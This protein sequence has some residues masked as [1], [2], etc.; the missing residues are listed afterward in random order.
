[1]LITLSHCVVVRTFLVSTG[2]SV[3]G[4]S[5]TGGGSACFRSFFCNDVL[6]LHK[7]FF[8]RLAGLFSSFRDK[9]ALS[10]MFWI[11]LFRGGSFFSSSPTGLLYFVDGFEETDFSLI[12]T[13]GFLPI[14]LVTS[15][16]RAPKTSGSLY[17]HSVDRFPSGRRISTAY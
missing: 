15:F 1:M 2:G 16:F 3:D 6:C 13:A 7:S 17:T 9:F 4:A 10:D 5:A 14:S 8:L 11:S 12:A